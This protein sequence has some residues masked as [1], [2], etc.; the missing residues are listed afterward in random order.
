MTNPVK[1]TKIINA[2]TTPTKRFF[3]NEEVSS[4][5]R[6]FGFSG[7]QKKFDPSQF[8]PEKVVIATDADADGCKAS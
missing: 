4:L 7:Y 1:I 5:F 3:E 6:I 8:R 2:L